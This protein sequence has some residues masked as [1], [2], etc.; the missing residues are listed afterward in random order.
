VN[1]G[2]FKKGEKRPGQGR[3][4]GTSNKVTGDVKDMILKALAQAG[5][6][7]YLYVQSIE[8]PKAFLTLVGRVLPLQVTGEDGGALVIRVQQIAAPSE[9][10]KA[11]TKP[12]A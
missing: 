1:S 7:N 4:K 10:A 6:V 9:Q 2:T 3:P 5:G 12:S 11:W 8:N